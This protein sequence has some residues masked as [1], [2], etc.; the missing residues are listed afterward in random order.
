MTLVT[1]HQIIYGQPFINGKPAIHNPENNSFKDIFSDWQCPECGSY[2]SPEPAL[3]CLNACHLS[4]ASYRR[5][6]QQLREADVACQKEKRI[7]EEKELRQAS[8]SP[9]ANWLESES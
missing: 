2:L 5:F 3:I 6:H 9:F 8:Q 4:A 7:R 1:G